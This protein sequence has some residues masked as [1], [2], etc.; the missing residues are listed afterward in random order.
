[1]KQDWQRSHY[2]L[3]WMLKCPLKNIKNTDVYY[4]TMTLKPKPHSANSQPGDPTEWPPISC[5]HSA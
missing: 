1:M 3:A 5:D 2:V 4:N